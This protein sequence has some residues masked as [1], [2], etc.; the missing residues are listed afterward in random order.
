MRLDVH[1]IDWENTA[2]GPIEM[3][4]D[5]DHWVAK[6]EQVRLGDLTRRYRI[7]R[8][9]HIGRFCIHEYVEEIH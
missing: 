8:I 3:W 6:D 9:E 1:F 4:R 5:A 2:A 7:V